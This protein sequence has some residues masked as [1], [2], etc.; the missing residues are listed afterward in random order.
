MT[1]QYQKQTNMRRQLSPNHPLAMAAQA[2]QRAFPR[3]QKKIHDSSANPTKTPN[4]LK[5]AEFSAICNFYVHAKQ[6]PDYRVPLEVGDHHPEPVK[7][8]VKSGNTGKDRNAKLDIVDALAVVIVACV[9]NGLG[10][11]WQVRVCS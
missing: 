10:A 6:T 2:S 7:E 8:A 5:G 3:K 11:R 4:A 9:W 1:S